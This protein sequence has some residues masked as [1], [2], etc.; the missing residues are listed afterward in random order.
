MK[1]PGKR[2]PALASWVRFP[3]LTGENRNVSVAGWGGEGPDPHVATYMR[4]SKPNLAPAST[5][6][7]LELKPEKQHFSNILGLINKYLF[8]LFPQNIWIFSPS[9]N[10]PFTHPPNRFFLNGKFGAEGV[11]F[12][13]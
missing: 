3:G 9:H 13:W 12:S 4:G 2:K 10:L 7:G 5:C 6:K 11:F 8:Q 1:R